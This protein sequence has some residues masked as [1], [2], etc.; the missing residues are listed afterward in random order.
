MNQLATQQPAIV[1]ILQRDRTREEMSLVCPPD[2]NVDTLL[3]RARAACLANPDLMRC[4][5]ASILLAVKKSV[6]SG[7]ELNGRDAHLVPYGNKCQFQI[8]WKGFVALGLRCG[9]RSIVAEIVYEHD[10]FKIWTDDSGR[11]CEHSIDVRNPRGA[12]LGA[13]CRT[14]SKDGVIDFEWMSAEQILAIKSRSRGTPW[15]TDEDE[16]WRKTAIRRHSKRWDIDTR[17][18]RAIEDDD[19]RLER[20]A[21]KKVSLIVGDEPKQISEPTPEPNPVHQIENPTDADQDLF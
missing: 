8:D 14:E 2:V 3:A 12:K 6:S 5:P 1:Q 9:L 11:H 19:D 10:H 17:F 18:K 4:D 21:Q 20:T 15:K 7:L 16:M 13:F